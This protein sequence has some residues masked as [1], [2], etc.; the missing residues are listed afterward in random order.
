M[1]TPIDHSAIFIEKLIETL[2]GNEFKNL[3]G[4]LDTI[5]Y[6]N[7]THPKCCINIAIKN[8]NFCYRGNKQPIIVDIENNK[9]TLLLDIKNVEYFLYEL[10]KSK[11]TSIWNIV[12]FEELHNF[13]Y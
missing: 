2:D 10:L 1:S 11:S 9:E 13:H 8:I 6:I 4:A 3:V 5:L 12:S 7:K